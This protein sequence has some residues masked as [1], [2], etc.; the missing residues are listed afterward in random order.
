MTDDVA[1]NNNPVG[2]MFAGNSSG[3]MAIANRIDL[4]L[5][6]FDVT[7]DDGVVPTPGALEITTASLPNGTV[8]QAYSA[9]LTATGGTTPYGW[10]L[11]TGDSLP[12]GLSLDGTAGEISGILTAEGIQS[13]T[14]EVTDNDGATDT[15]DLSINVNAAGGTFS[16]SVSYA[17]EGGQASAYHIHRQRRQWDDLGRNLRHTLSN[18]TSGGLW[19]P[20]TDTTGADG[21]VTFTLK[22]APGGCFSVTVHSADDG[23]DATVTDPGLCK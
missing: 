10:A 23:W 15:Q 4:V 18:D 13:F 8:G 5:E 22:N 3:T 6:A 12:A 21:T 11:V 1:E 14:V 2:L 9:T 19:G 16:L 7:I 20:V 17:T